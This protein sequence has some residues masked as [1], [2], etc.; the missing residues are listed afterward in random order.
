MAL[1]AIIRLLFPDPKVRNRVNG[2]LLAIVVG[3]AVLYATLNVVLAIVVGTTFGA[4]LAGG[5]WLQRRRNLQAEALGT[6]PVDLS[7]V[8]SGLFV[9]G[10]ISATA[11]WMATYK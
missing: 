11:V 7:K 6:K 5:F 9:V 2:A 3:A 1:F 4:L 10:M 8:A